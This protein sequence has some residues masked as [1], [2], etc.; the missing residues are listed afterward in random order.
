MKK[1]ES[2]TQQRSEGLPFPSI[3][4]KRRA[5]DQA[6]RALRI[7][8][9]RSRGLKGFA[10]IQTAKRERHLCRLSEVCT[11]AARDGGNLDMGSA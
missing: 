10:R 6:V 1:R 2:N 5:I 3:C 4:A 8:T 11:E 9:K 7:G